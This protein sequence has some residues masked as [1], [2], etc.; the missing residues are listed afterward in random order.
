MRSTYHQI[1]FN[2]KVSMSLNSKPQLN[3]IIVKAT[4]YKA[5]IAVFVSLLTLAVTT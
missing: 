1:T 5:L 4:V 2:L 3:I